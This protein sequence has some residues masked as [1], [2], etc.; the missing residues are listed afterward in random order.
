ME[1]HLQGK[2]ED[3]RRQ[4]MSIRQ[5]TGEKFAL[6]LLWCSYLCNLSLMIWCIH[7]FIQLQRWFVFQPNPNAL[8][9]SGN[10]GGGKNKAL[11]WLV[12]S[13]KILVSAIEMAP[14]LFCLQ[15]Q[16]WFTHY[17][18]A[19]CTYIFNH[20]YHCHHFHAHSPCPFTCRL[21]IYWWMLIAFSAQEQIVKEQTNASR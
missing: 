13:S 11:M 20:I 12:G 1:D 17:Q 2:E 16:A 7:S 21:H 10:Q 18:Y 19:P 6:N 4:Q 15:V 8:I 5:Q 9:H 3:V 14:R